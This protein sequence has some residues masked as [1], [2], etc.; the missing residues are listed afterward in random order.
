MQIQTGPVC[1]WLLVC[2]HKLCPSSSLRVLPPERTT[3]FLPPLITCP[4]TPSS[5][6]TPHP[7]SCHFTYITV[8]QTHISL[9]EPVPSC[10]QKGW[11]ESGCTHAETSHVPFRSTEAQEVQIKGQFGISIWILCR[12]TTTCAHTHAC[13]HAD[14]HSYLSLSQK[15]SVANNTQTTRLYPLTKPSI[16]TPAT[17][18]SVIQLL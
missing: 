2:I 9:M 4:Q 17:M 6:L 1:F 7:T 12:K 15:H 14:K 5:T 8:D 3:A 13:T 16:P 18:F 10:P 11:R